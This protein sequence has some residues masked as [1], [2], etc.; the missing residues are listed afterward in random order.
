MK[1]ETLRELIIENLEE[2]KAQEI[3]ALNVKKLTDITDFMVICSGTS[4]RHVH[5]IAKNLI[6][7]IKQ[8]QIRPLGVEEEPNGAWTLV[9]FGDVVVHIMLPGTREFYNLEKL[10]GVNL[11]KQNRSQKL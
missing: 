6:D 9:D 7:K 5:A 11:A 10:W 8:H 2:L 4:S 1:P 3:V